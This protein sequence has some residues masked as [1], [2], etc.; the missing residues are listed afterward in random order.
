M[1]LQ[2]W[3]EQPM[4]EARLLN[5]AFLSARA[6]SCADG[7]AEEDDAGLPYPLVFVALPVVLHRPTRNALPRS[8]RTSLAAWLGEHPR[9]LVGFAERAAS[10]VPTVKS[11]LLFASGHGLLIMAGER[12]R[13][14]PRPRPMTL[15]QR[16]ATDEVRDCLKRGR[17]VGQWFAKAG[18]AGTVMALWGVAP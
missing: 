12:V 9:A 3:A 11:A 18:P 17:F 4:E 7:Y 5:P 1:S 6:W 13:A 15:F 8:T 2:A 14:G 16:Q 10:L